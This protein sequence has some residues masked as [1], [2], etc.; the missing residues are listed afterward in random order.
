MHPNSVKPYGQTRGTVPLATSLF[1]Y[2][3]STLYLRQFFLTC[4][5]SAEIEQDSLIQHFQEFV[6]VFPD[7]R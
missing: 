1:L 5:I 7:K 4:C 3:V 2:A 6:H